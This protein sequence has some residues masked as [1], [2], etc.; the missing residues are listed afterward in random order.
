[1]IVSQRPGGRSEVV[2]TGLGVVSPIGIGRAPFWE[3]LCAGTTG[4]A[5]IDHFDT[6][7]LPIHI[8][9]RVRDFDPAKYVKPRKSLKVMSREI[10]FAVTAADLAMTDAGFTPETLDPERL[11]VLLGCDW[12]QPEPELVIDASRAVIAQGPLDVPNWGRLALAEIYPLWL[13]KYLPNMPACHVAIAHDARGPCNSIVLQEVSSLLA[14]REAA[15]IIERGAADAI[16]AGGTGHRLH[17]TTYFRSCV[18][19]VSHRND[20]PAGASRP[21]AKGRDGLVNGEGSAMFLLESRQHAQAR[22]ARILASVL[23][24]SSGCEARVPGGPQTSTV[25]ARVLSQALA[26]AKLKPG[27]IGH[28]NAHG[29][30]TVQSDRIEAQAIR[31]VLGDVPV[32]APK[33]YF[34][35]LGAGGGA[36]EMAVSVLALAEGLVPRTLNHEEPAEDCPIRVIDREPL[37][38][39]QPTA[40]LTNQAVTGQSVALVLG[41]H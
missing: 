19:E 9:A 13:L 23:G 18:E 1:L 21:F 41:G 2:I 15:R 4:V 33:S 38:G 10:Q 6:K 36:V 5:P 16:I 7:A 29:M 12:I 20:D 26:D 37:T 28:V 17:P 30:S 34:G 14:I 39:A 11:G 40:L 24:S 35:H 31:A 27:D 32:T 3:S 25:L 8:G 22:G